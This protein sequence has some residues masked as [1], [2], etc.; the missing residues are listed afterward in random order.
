MLY[1]QYSLW[2]YNSCVLILRMLSILQ[3]D[4]L[5]YI[6]MSFQPPFVLN[7][8]IECFILFFTLLPYMFR[9]LLIYIWIFWPFVN[10][11]NLCYVWVPLWLISDRQWSGSWKKVNWSI[12][13]SLQVNLYQK[14]SLN[15]NAESHIFVKDNWS[16]FCC[17]L[18]F[19]SS[20]IPQFSWRQC[21]TVKKL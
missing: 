4:N 2:Y 13:L 1:S 17:V 3:K 11:I 9:L 12:P 15:I 10:V 20:Y 16:Y 5:I 14:G 6:N 8:W 21:V 18:L 7:S 19:F